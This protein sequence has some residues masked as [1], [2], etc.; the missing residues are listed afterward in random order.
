[1]T[2]DLTVGMVCFPSLG[3]SGIIATELAKGLAHRGHRVHV[4]ASAPPSRPLPAC[5]RLFF[6]EVAVP[7][8]PLLDHAPYTLA[9]ASSLVELATEHRFD[10][11]HVHYAVPHAAS[12]YLA[13]RVLGPAAPRFVITLHGTDVT[14]VGSDPSY[15]PIT[16]F[17]VGRFDGITVPSEFL[18]GEAHRLLGL[19]GGTPIEVIPNFVDTDHFT[20]APLRDRAHFDQLFAATGGTA[21]DDGSP[22]L[23]HVSSF[24]AVK[25]AA[26]LIDVLA[27]IRRHGP[28]RLVLIGDGPDRHG[29]MQ[30]A[31]ELDVG[32]Y[33]PRLGMSYG[34]LAA[35]SPATPKP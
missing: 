27:G 10:V 13:R 31:R 6:H 11:V 26:D 4:I 16:R 3:G 8:Y 5:E 25:R 23:F 20:P 22:V 7:T 24:R 2:S 32:A 17:A 19:P 28:A 14:H 1:M 35:R 12:A 21:G 29:L 9:V 33:D 15:R 34:E 30:R 18:K